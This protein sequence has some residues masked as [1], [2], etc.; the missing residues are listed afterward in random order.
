MTLT[1]LYNHTANVPHGVWLLAYV[2]ATGDVSITGILAG[3]QVGYD[4]ST[5]VPVDDKFVPSSA[6]LR[7]GT[8]QIVPE[9][10][11]LVL[12]LLPLVG[13]GFVSELTQTPGNHVSRDRKHEVF[14]GNDGLRR[15][16]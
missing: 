16:P 14:S 12:A 9:P 11:A 1:G 2:V 4:L 5:G 8:G 10:S 13:L 3:G 15:S 6:V 7:Y